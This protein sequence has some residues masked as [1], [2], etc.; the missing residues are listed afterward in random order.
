MRYI[1]R[2]DKLLFVVLIIMGT[3]GFAIVSRHY[4]SWFWFGLTN[5]VGGSM[6]G[7]W[8]FGTKSIKTRSKRPLDF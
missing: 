7:Q 1:S 3:T 8:W 2:T 6:F 4:E 5:F